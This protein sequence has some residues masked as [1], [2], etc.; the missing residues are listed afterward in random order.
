MPA[1]Y[2]PTTAV[3]SAPYRSY[4]GGSRVVFERMYE[5]A[6]YVERATG[7]TGFVLVVVGTMGVLGGWAGGRF[8]GGGWQECR[9]EGVS[10]WDS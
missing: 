5:L 3:I 4:P 9:E 8:I 6:S 7:V 1:H 2:R 10:C